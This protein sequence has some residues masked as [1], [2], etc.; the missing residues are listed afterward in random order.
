MKAQYDIYF[1][2]IDG[3][4]WYTVATDADIGAVLQDINRDGHKVISI[5][6]KYIQP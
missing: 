5:E 1:R 3:T 6:P 2:K 4:V